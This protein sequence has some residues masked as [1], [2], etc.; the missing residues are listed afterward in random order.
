MNNVRLTVNMVDNSQ[1]VL[2]EKPISHNLD[3][4]DTVL[5]AKS[6]L[7]LDTINAADI[8][9]SFKNPKQAQIEY[10]DDLSSMGYLSDRYD[11]IDSQDIIYDSDSDNE[12]IIYDNDSDDMSYDSDDESIEGD[13][14]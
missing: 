10:S 1:G 8:L 14:L 9:T 2:S 7:D 13:V 5:V 3:I 6:L 11:D 4:I 12:D